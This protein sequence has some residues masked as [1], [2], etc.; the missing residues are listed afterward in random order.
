MRRA[1]LQCRNPIAIFFSKHTF[2]KY[3]IPSLKTHPDTKMPL[4]VVAKVLLGVEVRKYYLDIYCIL[5]TSK[6]KLANH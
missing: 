4:N 6:I 2:W 5:L 3:L 1:M